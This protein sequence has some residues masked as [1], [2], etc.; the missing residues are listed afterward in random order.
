MRAGSAVGFGLVEDD[1]LGEFVVIEFESELRR[2]GKPFGAKGDLVIGSGRDGAERTAGGK[3]G[4]DK[5]V[6][7]IR[8][9]GSEDFE[10]AVAAVVDDVGFL[11]SAEKPPSGC[12]AEV[13]VIDELEVRAAGVFD[14][15]KVIEEKFA[16]IEQAK[17]EFVEVELA[18]FVNG[19]VS[20]EGI[21]VGLPLG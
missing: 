10:D 5:V 4:F 2:P 8:A 6:E 14:D 9:G 18:W 11:M 13:T 17:A 19:S 20:G 7:V 3:I 16:G 15:R 21:G 1:E 12:G